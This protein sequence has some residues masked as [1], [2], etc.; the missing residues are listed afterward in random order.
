MRRI[1]CFAESSLAHKFHS[2]LMVS[3]IDSEVRGTDEGGFE[4]WILDEEDMAKAREILK[5][6]QDNIDDVKFIIA[7]NKFAK[8]ASV[9][10]ERGFQLPKLDLGLDWLMPSDSENRMTRL[11]II[12]CV[13]I[14]L[15][16]LSGLFN[17]FINLLFFSQYRYPLFVEI[18]E[19]Q[20]WRLITPI[21]LHFGILHIV[22]NMLWLYQL[23]SLI[24]TINGPRYLLV[25][26]LVIGVLANI[27]E[28]LVT[29]GSFGGMSGVVYGLLGFI[30][31]MAKY[32]PRSGYYIDN[33][34][35]IFM[36]V[37]LVICMTG[38]IGHIANTNHFIGLMSGIA[39]GYFASRDKKTSS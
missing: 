13:A 9:P 15:M 10:K 16:M 8:S 5:E 19:G 3:H 22:F 24:E 1:E 11:L 29:G 18:F 7:E 12:I 27:A 34:I 36:L 39:W 20:I 38:Y 4:V 32:K 33:A 23:G 31:M 21:F 14:F 37:W 25:M 6:F 35:F 26:V 17:G 28:S 30:W 2:Y